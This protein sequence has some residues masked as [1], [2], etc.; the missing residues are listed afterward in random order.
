MEPYPEISSSESSPSKSKSL[1]VAVGLVLTA[2]LA[3]GIYQFTKR[4]EPPPA[5]PS[6]RNEQTGT[7]PTQIFHWIGKISRLEASAIIVNTT[8]EGEESKRVLVTENTRITRL[9]FIPVEENGQRKFTPRETRINS[10]RDLKVGM[11]VQAIAAIDINGVR[12]FE[13]TQIRILP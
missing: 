9:A 1:M 8:L 2:A 5:P 6:P 10:I 7:A 12:E 3:W 4:D 13:A 11:S